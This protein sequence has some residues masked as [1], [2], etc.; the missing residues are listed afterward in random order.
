MSTWHCK[1]IL[2]NLNESKNADII[3]IFGEKEY[4]SSI[5]A[6]N[7]IAIS[8]KIKGEGVYPNNKSIIIFKKDKVQ[9]RT[10]IK[11]Q[12]DQKNYSTFNQ[13]QS[14]SAKLWLVEK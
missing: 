7:D 1:V 14:S 5:Q 9:I 2:E 13:S 11:K 6:N 12:S 4:N 8:F 3:L 10:Q